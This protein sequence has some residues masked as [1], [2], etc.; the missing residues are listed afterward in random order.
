MKTR[1]SLEAKSARMMVNA[2]C[3]FSQTQMAIKLLGILETYSW[4][5]ITLHSTWRRILTTITDTCRWESACRRLRN[6]NQSTNLSFQQI[7]TQTAQWKIQ[8]TRKNREEVA[9]SL[10]SCFCAVGELQLIITG[11]RSSK[12]KLRPNLMQTEI[13]HFC[14]IKMTNKAK[15]RGSWAWTLKKSTKME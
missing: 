2:S 1:S 14:I 12:M 5:T 13:F 4:R 6:M 8:S 7:I 15:A 9:D 3:L 10:S 11:K